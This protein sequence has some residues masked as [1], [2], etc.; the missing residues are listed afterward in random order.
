MAA[1]SP[2]PARW[3]SLSVASL[4]TTA[5]RVRTREGVCL[6]GEEGRDEGVQWLTLGTQFDTCAVTFPQAEFLADSFER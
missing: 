4:S 2:L 5:T 6:S 3:F 1:A